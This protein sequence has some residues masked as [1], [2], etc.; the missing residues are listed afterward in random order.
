MA[1][2]REVEL[3]QHVDKQNTQAMKELKKKKVSQLSVT[4]PLFIE[5]TVVG[6]HWTWLGGPRDGIDEV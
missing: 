5:K 4:F 2:Q 1:H 6:G 3:F